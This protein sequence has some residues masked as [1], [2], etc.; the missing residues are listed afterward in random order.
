MITEKEFEQIKKESLKKWSDANG[1][2]IET[3]TDWINDVGAKEC[4]F[5]INFNCYENCPLHDC[6]KYPPTKVIKYK[7]SLFPCCQ[8]YFNIIKAV[9]GFSWHP[10]SFEK[11][12]RLRDEV[13][14]IFKINVDKLCNRIENITYQDVIIAPSRIKM[15]N[16]NQLIENHEAKIIHSQ[17]MI[18]QYKVELGKNLD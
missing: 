16:I 7:S 17:K 4:S 10:I 1:Q 9:V 14:E 12:P 2:T 18:K 3:F 6:I 8:E 13:F 11:E 15:N 5:C